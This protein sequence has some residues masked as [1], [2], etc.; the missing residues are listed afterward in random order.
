MRSRT[1]LK[2]TLETT[3]PLSFF[4]FPFFSLPSSLPS[5]PT[6]F[7]VQSLFAR[8]TIPPFFFLTVGRFFSREERFHGKREGREQNRLA[9]PFPA[10]KY[11][12]FIRWNSNDS[13]GDE[14]Y[15][16]FERCLR[17]SNEFEKDEA[18]EFIFAS[19]ARKRRDRN[20]P[21]RCVRTHSSRP[22]C[23]HSSYKYDACTFH[24][25][26]RAYCKPISVSSMCADKLRFEKL[27]ESRAYTRPR[28]F[29][30]APFRQYAISVGLEFSSISFFLSSGRKNLGEVRRGKRAKHF[31]RTFFLSFFLPTR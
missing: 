11:S 23:P 27:N 3:L 22:S 28:R 13:S 4:F 15:P 26:S 9:S 29:S 31:P 14:V 30:N 20:F 18:A 10:L 19:I 2:Q 5:P 12:A 21:D 16:V 1:L 24:L 25:D 17:W 6:I 8:K 7:A